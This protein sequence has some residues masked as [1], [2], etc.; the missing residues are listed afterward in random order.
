MVSRIKALVGEVA[1]ST[2]R[3][4]NR[5]LNRKLLRQLKRQLLP[6]LRKQLL[7][8]LKK[9]LVPQ[10][11][12]QLILNQQLRKQLDQQLRRQVQQSPL[13]Q[14][15]CVVGKFFPLQGRSAEYILPKPAIRSGSSRENLPVPPMDLLQGYWPEDYLETGRS[16][17]ETMLGILEGVGESP[18]TLTRVLDF[19]CAAGRML[20][21]YPHIPGRSELW[22]VDI[23]AK[24]ISWCQQ[25]LSPPL[26]FAMATT[27][28]HLPFEDNYFDLVYCG[29]VFTHVSDLGDTWLLELRRIL[30]SGGYAYITIHDKQTVELLF[31]KYKD[32]KPLSA[33][34]AMVRRFDERTS[35]FSHDYAQFSIGADPESQVFYDREYLVQ[36][37]SRFA[38]VLSVT[39]EAYAYQTA[40]LV[41]K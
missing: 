22:G 26:L 6:Q 38:T 25:N 11:R 37:W 10:L 12:K 5:R 18:Q 16:N 41:Q 39:P 32:I 17:I 21:F 31:T 13:L 9:Q 1:Y 8:Q 29:S 30:R 20:R 40:I 15:P 14:D 3:P 4:L 23:S 35:V 24:H 19:G 36:K 34:R 2:L 27:S 7:R 33:F 28:P